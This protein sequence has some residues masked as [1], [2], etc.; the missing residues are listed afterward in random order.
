MAAPQF[1]AVLIATPQMRS[2]S[3]LTF[4]SKQSAV[5]PADPRG[6]RGGREPA[7]KTCYLP[8]FHIMNRNLLP[9]RRIS[10]L[11][12]AGKM[13]SERIEFGRFVLDLGQYELTC[14]GKPVHIERIPMDLLILLVREDGRLVGREEIIKKLW[15]KGL[16]FDT[17]NSINTAIR[18]IRYALGHD[19]GNPQY[20][21]TVLGKG[22]RFRNPTAHTRAGRDGE[23]DPSRIMLAVL[24]FENLS[25]DPAQEY[26][27][28]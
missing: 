24:P 5:W 12:G 28:D 19:S 22:Y 20:V 26:F 21:E 18:K 4:R 17:D 7:G 9:G 14:A 1:K 23:A 25:G 10:V 6:R 8:R 13:D 3:G 2:E 16:H 27:S 11:A 15:G